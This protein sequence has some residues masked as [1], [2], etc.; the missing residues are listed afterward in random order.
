[1]STSIIKPLSNDKLVDEIYN[2]SL[3]V[4][5]GVRAIDADNGADGARYAFVLMGSKLVDLA[6]HYEEVE[7]ITKQQDKDCTIS[8][9]KIADELYEVQCLVEMLANNIEANNPV[10]SKRIIKDIS[11]ILCPIAE[12]FESGRAK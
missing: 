3:L 5:H 6:N 8:D 7:A 11:S 10:A 1:M 2:L 9:T 4:D 12:H